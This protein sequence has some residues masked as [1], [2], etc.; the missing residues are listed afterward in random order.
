MADEVRDDFVNV[1]ALGAG[2]LFFGATL[3][4]SSCFSSITFELL[5]IIDD[6]VKDLTKGGGGARLF[7][8]G[9]GWILLVLLG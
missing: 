1:G 4:I 9:G 5:H 6:T 7:C 2:V 8:L 3:L